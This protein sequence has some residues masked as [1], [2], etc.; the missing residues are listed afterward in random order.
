MK[1]KPEDIIEKGGKF[2]WYSWHLINEGAKTALDYFLFL[3]LKCL[4]PAYYIGF[5]LN[6]FIKKS[7]PPKEKYL[8]ISV[9]NLTLGGTGKSPCVEFILK[10]LLSKKRKVGLLTIGYGRKAQDREEIIFSKVKNNITVEEMGDESYLF[11]KHFP[12]VPIFVSRNRAKSLLHATGRR[13]CDVFIMDDGFQYTGI[14]KDLEILLINKRNPFGNGCL[15]PAGSLREPIDS[16]KRADLLILTHS[17]ESDAVKNKKVK[18]ILSQKAPG[19]PVLESIHKPL[20]LKDAVSD[21]EYK[22]TKL[23]GKRILCL[24]SL[25]DPVSF[26]ETFKKLPI[27]IAKNIRFPDHY[28]YKNE[29]IK[30]LYNTAKKEKVDFVVTTEKD[31]V[32]FPKD[33]QL[34]VPTLCL[35]VDFKITTGEDIIDNF[36]NKVLERYKV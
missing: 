15:V 7:N 36:I 24:S 35:I 19:I 26:E 31:L 30:W 5:L 18:A 8:V 1:N 13:E 2:Y 6:R 21:E 34:S 3:I 27:N 17:D 25:A 14:D 12:K 10:K 22:L 9:G 33:S 28:V 29:D 23:T 32:R 11:S 16:A 4:I 20:R